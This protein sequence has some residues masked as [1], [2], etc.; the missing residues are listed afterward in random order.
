MTIE[1]YIRV[2]AGSFV[3]LS[4]LLGV[5]ASPLFVSRWFLWLAAF[6]GANLLQFGFTNFCPMALILKKLGVPESRLSC[7]N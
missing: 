6:V 5:D 7:G 3:L 4:L 1:R 2:F